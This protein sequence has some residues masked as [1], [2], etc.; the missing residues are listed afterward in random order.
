[1]QRPAVA[2]RAVVVVGQQYRPGELDEA[3]HD[4]SVAVGVGGE[5]LQGARV[6]PAVRPPFVDRAPSASTTSTSSGT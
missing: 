2:G 1:M 4:R 6:G 5:A 3:L